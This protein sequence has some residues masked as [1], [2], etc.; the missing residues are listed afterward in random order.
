MSWKNIQGPTGIDGATVYQSATFHQGDR[1]RFA[2]KDANAQCTGMAV[3]AIAALPLR[4]E[5]V[6]R[7]FLD[8]ILIECDKYYRDSKVHNKVEV[9]HLAVDEL[10]TSYTIFSR[11][12]EIEIEEETIFKYTLSEFRRNK[13]SYICRFSR[14]VVVL[15]FLLKI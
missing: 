13:I 8:K 2:H 7:D 10:L 4:I 6:S 3:L 12:V 9:A 15:T 14:K 11:A 1:K 5:Y